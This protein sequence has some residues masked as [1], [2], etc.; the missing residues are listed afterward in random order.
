MRELSIF[1]D[2]SG[3]FGPYKLHSPF[4]I[5]TL[6]FHEQSTDISTNINHLNDKIRWCGLP[7]TP[8]HTG[9]LIRK[10]NEYSNLSPR[11]AAIAS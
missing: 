2:E 3:D 1:V 10:E 4:Y 9:P 8:V 11:E 5:V 6:V 7:E